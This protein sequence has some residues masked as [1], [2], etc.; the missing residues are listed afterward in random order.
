MR[1]SLLASIAAG[2]L[3]LAALSAAS[4]A[5]DPIFINDFGAEA[6]A[7]A[8]ITSGH[9]PVRAS[10]GVAPLFWSEALAASAQAWANQC[11]DLVAPA[12]AL[13]HNPNRSVGFPWYVGENIYATN[14]VAT[15]QGAVNNWA[16]EA[17]YY[18]YA[19]NT[20]AGGH[21][22]GHYTQMVWSTTILVGCGISSC[23]GLI[24]PNS[25]VCDYAPGGNNGARPY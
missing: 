24:F 19:T 15:A 5:D 4:A 11:V 18:D 17:A 8:G 20:C 21:L 9:N 23:P 3:G 25:I 6:P 2:V 22:C 14:G 10:V 12:G 13:D 16:S 1:H 7:L